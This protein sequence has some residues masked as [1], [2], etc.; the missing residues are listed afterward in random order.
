MA[1]MPATYRPPGYKQRE[2]AWQSRQT[3]YR[4]WYNLWL[5][6]KPGGLR[7]QALARDPICKE[8]QRRGFVVPATQA[9]HIRPHAGDWDLFINIENI[10]GLCWGCHDKKTKREQAEGTGG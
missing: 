3:E 7:E 1:H 4:D 6:R 8:C 10:Q 5:W 9:D 2:K